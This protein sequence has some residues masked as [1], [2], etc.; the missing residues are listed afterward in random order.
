MSPETTGANNLFEQ[1]K[2]AMRDFMRQ[3]HGAQK[4]N[5]RVPYWLHPQEVAEILLTALQKT[6]EAAIDPALTTDMFL[7][8]Q[9][10]DLYEDTK[11]SRQEV[12]EKFGQQVDEFINNLTNRQGDQDRV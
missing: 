10:H 11:A 1:K 4:R 9:G 7:A 6:D 5:A 12:Q 3:A 2:I 8:A